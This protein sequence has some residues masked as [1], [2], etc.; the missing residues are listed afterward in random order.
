MRDVADSWFTEQHILVRGPLCRDENITETV[1]FTMFFA[2]VLYGHKAEEC[3]ITW[4][5]AQE[6]DRCTFWT[7]YSGLMETSFL[8]HNAQHWVQLAYGYANLG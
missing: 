2:F 8:V 4:P 7:S 5:I 6:A 1:P 3:N